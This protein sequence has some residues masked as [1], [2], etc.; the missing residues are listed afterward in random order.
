MKLNNKLRALRQAK[1][2]TMKKIATLIG[3]PVSTYRDWE[4]GSKVPAEKIHEI[5]KIFQISVSELFGT[6]ADSNKE[7]LICLLEEALDLVKN[8]R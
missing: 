6:E 3:I 4:Y 1:R 8:T 5:A 7:K 2:M